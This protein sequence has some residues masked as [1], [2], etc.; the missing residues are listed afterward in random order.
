[1]NEKLRQAIEGWSFFNETC[2]CEQHPDLDFEHDGCNG[3]GMARALRDEETFA[4]S[5]AAFFNNQKT[6]R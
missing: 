3:L 5:K 6:K 4:K 2:I 1:M